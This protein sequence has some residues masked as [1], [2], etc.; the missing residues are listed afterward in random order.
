MT[1][2]SYLPPHKGQQFEARPKKLHATYFSVI[3]H[4]KIPFR[5]LTCY[6]N[7]NNAEQCLLKEQREV[8]AA[9]AGAVHH[10]AKGILNANGAGNECISHGLDE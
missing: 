8:K 4:H 1:N 2:E 10:W 6:A 7:R 5:E 9:E 3:F